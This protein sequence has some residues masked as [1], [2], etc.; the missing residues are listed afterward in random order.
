M[1]SYR[2]YYSLSKDKYL[3]KY[4]LQ[5][6]SHYKDLHFIFNIP[7]SIFTTKTLMVKVHC[8]S[9]KGGIYYETNTYV[10][11]MTQFKD[12]EFSKI[13]EALTVNDKLTE[14]ELVNRA[15]ALSSLVEPVYEAPY[16]LVKNATSIIPSL[17][18]GKS[19]LDLKEPLCRPGFCFN[20][21][22]CVRVDHHLHCE[23]WKGYVGTNCH[24]TEKNAKFVKKKSC[25]T[26]I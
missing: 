9:L 12:L 1:D 5:E 10:N 25:K 11:I 14:N 6:A 4:P 24:I 7:D 13:T 23:C 18:Q 8:V 15:E 2:F 26:N 21:G 20:H 22:T 16:S 19:N 3:T 17:K